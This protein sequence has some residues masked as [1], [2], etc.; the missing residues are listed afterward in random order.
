MSDVVIR[1]LAVL[2]DI[3]RERERGD[4]RS[5]KQVRTDVVNRIA[6]DR[7]VRPPVVLDEIVTHL[8]P[9]IGSVAALERAIDGW[10]N[11]KSDLRRA[12]Q[13][14]AVD[15]I[16]DRSIAEFFKNPIV[17]SSPESTATERPAPNAAPLGLAPSPD[18]TD[19]IG[20]DDDVHGEANADDQAME[21]EAAAAAAEEARAAAEAEEARAH[22]ETAARAAEEARARAEAAAKARAEAER[23]AKAE[24]ERKAKAE[25]ER[26]AKAEAEAKEKAEAEARARAEAEE[27]AR[28]EA[29]EQARAEAEERARRAAEEKAEAEA[30]QAEA[31]A[32]AEAEERARIEAARKAQA[33]AA[34]AAAAEAAAREAAA[35]EAAAAAAAAEPADTADSALAR[36]T[37]VLDE[38]VAS[39][40]TDE[41]A[42]NDFLRASIAAMRVV[43]RPDGD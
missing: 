17:R 28:A 1:I 40:F 43:K 19:L 33:E 10:L 29:E 22:A 13:K 16:D 5:N 21:D 4:D 7:D 32:A 31:K 25:A 35:K 27:R 18:A 26:R 36:R 2:T 37:V 20:M 38:D 11:G 12:L 41:R 15:Q 23:K 9:D 39:F 42:V 30:A 24:A 6:H 14:H 3:Q 8:K 34:E